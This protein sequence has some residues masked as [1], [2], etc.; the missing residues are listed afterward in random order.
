M[1]GGPELPCITGTKNE[2]AN[3]VTI[4]PLPVIEMMIVRDYA[5][6]SFYDKIMLQRQ[7]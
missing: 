3:I 5:D 2:S 1:K 7:R 4:Q 6:C